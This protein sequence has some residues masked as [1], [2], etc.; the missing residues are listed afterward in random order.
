MSPTRP[1]VPRVTRRPRHLELRSNRK[2]RPLARGD[3]VVLDAVAVC[4]RVCRDRANVILGLGIGVGRRGVE[5]HTARLVIDVALNT[6]DPRVTAVLDDRQTVF[7]QEAELEFLPCLMENRAV[8]T[9]R[10]E[11]GFPAQF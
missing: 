7:T 8:P 4:G 9:D 10:T 6:V 3:F 11:R 5:R 1:E 2:P